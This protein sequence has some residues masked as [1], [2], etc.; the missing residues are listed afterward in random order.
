MVSLDGQLEG[1][2][3]EL[4][5]LVAGGDL[6]EYVIELLGEVDALLLGRVTY[7][8]F[9]AH[10]PTA[11]GPEAAL[12]NRLPKIVFSRRLGQ[13]SWANSRLVGEDAAREVEWLKRQPGK[14]LALV[15]SADLARTFLRSGLIDEIRALVNPVVLGAGRPM[16]AAVKERLR[17]RL[18]GVRTFGSG[19]VELRYDPRPGP[20]PA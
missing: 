4:D 5:W 13:L 14:A 20:P 18:L 7:E 17:L 16:F 10:W 11:K 2:K 9:A 6:R 12:L 1:A 3:R 15:G 19:V 8:L